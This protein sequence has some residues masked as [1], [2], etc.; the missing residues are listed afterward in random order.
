VTKSITRLSL[1]IKSK[2]IALRRTACR[3][4]QQSSMF[5]PNFYRYPRLILRFI[6]LPLV[7][8]LALDLLPIP[9]QQQLKKLK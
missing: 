3:L 4:R 5:S 9:A 8:Y 1:Y 7:A 6:L 2:G